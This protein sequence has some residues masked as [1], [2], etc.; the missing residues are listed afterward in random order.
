MKLL[1]ITAVLSYEK[2]AIN[3]FKKANIN[4][5]SSTSIKGFKTE[6][7]ENLLDNWFSSSKDEMQSL[8]FFS[9]TA[10]EKIN[11]VLKDLE[12]LNTQLPDSNPIR[13]IVLNIEKSL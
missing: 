13:A 5:F 10:E 4:A 9:F 2:E 1:I 8:L 7:S 11:Q 12:I 3:L 6:S